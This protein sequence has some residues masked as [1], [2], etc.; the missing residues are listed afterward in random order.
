MVAMAAV[1][2]GRQ[3]VGSRWCDGSGQGKEGAV[4]DD[5]KQRRR[6]MQALKKN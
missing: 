6:A 2:G 4:G 1:G 3:A 5:G